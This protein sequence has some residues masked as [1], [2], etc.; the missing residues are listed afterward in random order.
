MVLKAP[1]NSKITTP[2]PGEDLLAVPPM[3]EEQNNVKE[4][5]RNPYT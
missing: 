4:N 3:T 2:A 1:G 5:K